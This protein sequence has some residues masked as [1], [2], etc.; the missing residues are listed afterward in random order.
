MKEQSYKYRV[1]HV[2]GKELIITGTLGKSGAFKYGNGTSVQ[3]DV[4]VNGTTQT[5]L[6]DTRYEMDILP[7]FKKWLLK[8]IVNNWN[9]KSVELV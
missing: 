8:Y 4:E 3:L 7:D 9:V 2:S 1:I 6:L 5:E